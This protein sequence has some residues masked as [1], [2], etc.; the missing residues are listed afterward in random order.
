MAERPAVIFDCTC[1]QRVMEPVEPDFTHEPII[2]NLFDGKMHRCPD[3]FHGKR[4]ADKPPYIHDLFGVIPRDPDF[5]DP[6]HRPRYT[7]EQ[8]QRLLEGVMDILNEYQWNGKGTT[9]LSSLRKG[10]KASGILEPV[11]SEFE[12]PNG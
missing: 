8:H 6:D 7:Q 11:T 4:V 2:F 10:I 5:D 9:I 1:G 12:D 3:V